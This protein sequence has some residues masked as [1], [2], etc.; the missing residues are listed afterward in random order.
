MSELFEF[1]Q[2]TAA[3]EQRGPFY[4]EVLNRQKVRAAWAKKIRTTGFNLWRPVN[5]LRVRLQTA[6]AYRS[7]HG[8]C[9]VQC[10]DLG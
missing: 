8:L 10:P 2:E 7:G 4:L 5:N 1:L 9:L 6:R 3:F